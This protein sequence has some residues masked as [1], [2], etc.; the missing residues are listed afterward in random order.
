[1][2]N[3]RPWTPALKNSCVRYWVYL[4][5]NPWHPATDH[6]LLLVILHNGICYFERGVPKILCP[7]PLV[8]AAPDGG[9]MAQ[10]LESAARRRQP[11]LRNNDNSA[12]TATSFRGNA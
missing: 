1:M 4:E 8:L 7:V 5:S 6:W 9:L 11:R 10:T 3:F 12:T 2:V